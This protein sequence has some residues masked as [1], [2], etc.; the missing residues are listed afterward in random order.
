MTKTLKVVKMISNAII[1]RTN[2]VAKNC[3]R[4]RNLRN[5]CYFTHINPL[6][7]NS[8]TE[9]YH[10]HSRK[11][12]TN[13]LSASVILY[14][15]QERISGEIIFGISPVLS[16]LEAR[17]RNIYR[18]LV[19]ESIEYKNQRV[20][21]ALKLAQSMAK[22]QGIR[23]STVTRHD[24]NMYTNNRPHQGLAIDCSPLDFEILQDPP[25]CKPTRTNTSKHH[26]I[27]L[28]LDEVTDVQNL[29]AIARSAFFLG[30][31]GLI[32][33][34]KKAAPINAFSSKASAG[35]LEYLI[36]N[37]VLNMPKF[38]YR[39]SKDGWS[40]LGC[41]KCKEAV[42]ILDKKVDRPTILVLGSEGTGLRTA[43][44][45]VCTGFV[46]INPGL[47]SES[48]RNMDSLNVSVVAGILIFEL[49]NPR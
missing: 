9:K 11:E 39:C 18:L 21:A 19:S 10:T 44:R 29:G 32:V 7:S 5:P 31:D 6:S 14:C 15:N 30:V 1:D 13:S 25:I 49:S 24:L 45:N 17:R 22:K 8:K 3:L 20:V 35:A 33:C 38:L 4:F 2:W 26:A 42:C 43:I 48:L 41:D 47:S 34:S 23:I 37:N 12:R 46:T 16:A 40:V 28:A 36:V 27:W